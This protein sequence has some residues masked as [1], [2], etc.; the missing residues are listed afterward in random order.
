M[1][2]STCLSRVAEFFA[3]GG[4]GTGL[5]SE[6]SPGPALLSSSHISP[7]RVVPEEIEGPHVTWAAGG[8]WCRVKIPGVPPAGGGVRSTIRGFSNA[9]RRRLLEVVNSVDQRAAPASWF[10]FVTLTY[11]RSFP[12]AGASKR[13]LDAVLKRFFREFGERAVIWKLEPQDRGA[14]HYHLLVFMGGEF[15]QGRLCGWWANAWN[16]LVGA[17]DPRWHLKWHLGQLG[18]APCVEKARDWKGVALYVGK[19]LAKL[20]DGH[21]DWDQPGRF[22]GKRFS[23]MLPITIMSRKLSERQAVVLRRTLSRWYQSQVSGW[24]YVAGKPIGG[25]FVQGYRVHGSRLVDLGQGKVPFRSCWR[26]FGKLY[27]AEVR[28]QLRRR[29]GSRGGIGVFIGAGEFERLLEFVQVQGCNS[30]QGLSIPHIWARGRASVASQA[31][32]HHR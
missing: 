29:R 21:E 25:G 27:G 32:Q 22:W 13:D 28:E 1:E 3:D 4:V 30:S 24:F 26:E 18:N 7:Q 6:A 23:G 12:S 5:N 19:Y 2:L 11:P 9:S 14:P 16:E 31:S 8:R 10:A 20:C 17:S 15:D